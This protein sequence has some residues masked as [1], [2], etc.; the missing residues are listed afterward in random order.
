VPLSGSLARATNSLASDDMTSGYRRFYL[1]AQDPVANLA[2]VMTKKFLISVVDDDQCVREGL[3]HLIRSMDC[4]KVASFA[5][6]EEYL[7]SDVLPHTSCL[8]T[9]YQMPDMTGADLQNRL[10][11]DGYRIPII[12]LAANCNEEN[13]NRV[14][15]GGALCVLDKPLDEE[16]LFEWLKRVCSN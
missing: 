2:R 16:L 1:C 8:I 6:A 13:R 12:F 7:Q 5:S 10:I 3:E 4:Y 9:D 15:N 11:A 14:L